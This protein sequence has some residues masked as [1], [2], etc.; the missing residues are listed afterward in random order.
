MIQQ[1]GGYQGLEFES[2]WFKKNCIEQFNQIIDNVRELEGDIYVKGA[3]LLILLTRNRIWADGQKRTAYLTTK[4]F[5]EQNGGQFN[6]KEPVSVNRFLRNLTFKYSDL[7][8]EKWIKDGKEPV[9]NP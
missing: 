3:K 8:V 4:T 7:Q 2:N 9:S 6:E 1:F 5:V